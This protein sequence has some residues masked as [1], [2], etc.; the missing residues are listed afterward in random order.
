MYGFALDRQRPGMFSLGFKANREAP[1]QRW[2]VRVLPGRFKLRD[3]D[4]LPDVNSL[5]E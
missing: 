2:P 1:I 3:A 5:C 4:Q